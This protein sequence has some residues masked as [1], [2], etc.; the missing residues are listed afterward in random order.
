MCRLPQDSQLISNSF[1]ASGRNFDLN[2]EARTA[3]TKQKARSFR[4]L[5][6]FHH[7]INSDKVFGTHS[8]I[9]IVD[10]RPIIGVGLTAAFQPPLIA[11]WVPMTN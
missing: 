11:D 1:S 5:R 7:V 9:E 10:W 2:G 6:R 8:L 3:R 4:Q